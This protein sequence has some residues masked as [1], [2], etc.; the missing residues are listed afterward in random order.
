MRAILKTIQPSSPQTQQIQLICNQ[1]EP[2]YVTQRKT[3]KKYK[4]VG[5]EVRAK[6]IRCILNGWTIINVN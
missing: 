2:Q 4:K 3:T 1:V 6:L 5:K